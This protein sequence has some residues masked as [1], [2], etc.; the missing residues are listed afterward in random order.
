MRPIRPVLILALAYSLAACGDLPRP[1]AHDP[2]SPVGGLAR[3]SSGT[4]V[5]VLAVPDTSSAR[6]A[7]DLAA[8][9]RALDIPADATEAPRD[10]GYVLRPGTDG[11]WDLFGPRGALLLVLPADADLAEMGAMVADA[12]ERDA[13]RPLA[14]RMAAGPDLSGPASSGPASSAPAVPALRVVAGIEGLDPARGRILAGAVEEALRRG[15]LDIDSAAAWRVTGRFETASAPDG[16]PVPVRLT[17]TLVD[18]DGAARGSAEQANAVP[19]DTLTRGFAAL[20]A[21]IAPGAAEGVA[22]LAYE[23]RANL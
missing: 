15:G 6:F 10:G 3:L 7:G 8:A 4:G 16:Q 12:V 5:A 14:L 17:W 2:D 13:G 1:F 20:A 21:A 18:P 22:A 19:P 11:T 9:L 23:A